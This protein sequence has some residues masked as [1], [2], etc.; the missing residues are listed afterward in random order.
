MFFKWL[1]SVFLLLQYTLSVDVD[2]VVFNVTVLGNNGQPVTGLTEKDFRIYEDGREEK[3]KIF[4]PEDTPA[5]VGLVIDNS[6]S[7]TNKRNDVVRAALAFIDA[8]HPED[9]MFIVDFNRRAWLAMSS[10]KPFTSDR[11]E[12]RARLAETRAEGTTALYDALKLSLDHLKEGRRQRKALIVISDG[13]DNASVEKL[14]DVLRFAQQ[15]SATIFCIGIYD[16]FQKDR[17]PS[18]LKRIA[19]V[20]G[21]EALFPNSLESLHTIWPR[22]ANAIR[23]QYTIGYVSTNAVRDGGYRRVKITAKDRRG[24]LLD[25]RTRPGYIAASAP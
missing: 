5:T 3:I 1:L 17:N 14:D 19:R 22:I 11:S 16:P 25:V 6:G 7:M 13:G 4:Q 2:L 23:G 9:E 15:S 24:K 8:S 10:S 18:V 12:L 21:G 20:T